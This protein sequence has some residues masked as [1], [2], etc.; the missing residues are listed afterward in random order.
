MSELTPWIKKIIPNKPRKTKSRV[1]IDALATRQ[2]TN[3]R[4]IAE[5]PTA[6]AASP[7]R[8]AIS[9]RAFSAPAFFAQRF[10]GS[11]DP[12]TGLANLAVPEELRPAACTLETSTF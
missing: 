12:A 10:P 8:H 9:D 2:R 5:T 1:R 3:K 7:Y 6:N 4:V 11:A